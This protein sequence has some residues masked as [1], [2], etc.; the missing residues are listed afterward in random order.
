MARRTYLHFDKRGRGL[1]PP[2][3]SPVHATGSTIHLPQYKP[4][5][6]HGVPCCQDVQQ[7]FLHSFQIFSR[8][9]TDVSV[10]IQLKLNNS[11]LIY[12]LLCLALAEMK[13]CNDEQTQPLNA[14]RLTAFTS[15]ELQNPSGSHCAYS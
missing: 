9:L 13:T 10:L 8:C 14:T 15:F 6:S 3:L 5:N 1:S 4:R 2:G 7:M 12:F 11:V